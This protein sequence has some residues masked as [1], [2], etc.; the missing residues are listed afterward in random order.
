M[1]DEKKAEG[2]DQIGAKTDDIRLNLPK[3]EG[4]PRAG[5]TPRPNM[6]ST[7]ADESPGPEFK[8]IRWKGSP[9]GNEEVGAH[10]WAEHRRAHSLVSGGH[11][12]Y[13]EEKKDGGQ[14]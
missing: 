6:G 12:E 13:V 10:E 8:K 3:T 9:T 1:P 14:K 7:G 5:V 11:A 4:T 2:Q